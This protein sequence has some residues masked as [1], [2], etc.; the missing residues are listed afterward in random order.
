[1]FITKGIIRKAEQFILMKRFNTN[2][3]KI[4]SETPRPIQSLLYIAFSS[5]LL[6]IEGSNIDFTGWIPSEKDKKHMSTDVYELEKKKGEDQN[7]KVIFKNIKIQWDSCD[8]GNGYSCSH[9]NY[10]YS[11]E[12]K[13]ENKTHELDIEPEYICFQNKGKYGSLP[14]PNATIFDFIRMCQLCDIELELTDK[15]AS[16]LANLE[17][18]YNRQKSLFSFDLDNFRNK[19]I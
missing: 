8:C 14:I 12:I 18:D 15:A 11:I 17:S 19:S 16:L 10:V 4:N 6:D 13:N 9:P 5:I 7:S 2:K 1:L 3:M